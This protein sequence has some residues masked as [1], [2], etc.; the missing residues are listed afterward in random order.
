MQ[1]KQ[2]R[3]NPAQEEAVA[4]E[5]GP[6]LI[7]AGA[8]TGKT[9][10]LTSRLMKFIDAGIRPNRICAI[11]FTNKAA[12]EMADRVRS[13][14][15]EYAGAFIGTFHGLGA[16][17]LRREW[18]LL[19][20]GNNFVIFDDHDS[21]DLIK[22]IVK[23]ERW[24]QGEDAAVAKEKP[25]FF[26]NK[27]S[28]IKNK[29]GY[30]AELAS[31]KKE[32]D[33]LALKVY[34]A[35]EARLEENNALD[36][37]D[38]IEKVVQIL[39]TNPEALERH[40]KRFDAVLVDEYQDVNPKQYELVRLL[41]GGHRNVSVV[42]DDEQLIYGWRY[43]DL[44]IF[45]GFE[46]DWPGAEVK[47]LEENYRST[48]NVIEAASAVA[49]NN[50]YR[51]PK[52]LWTQNP[53]GEKIKIFEAYDENDEAELIVREIK[54]RNGLATAI[55]YRTNAQSRAIEQ[56]CIKNRIPYRIYGGLRFYE[57]KE[58]KDVIAAL[59]YGINGDEISRD[60][61]E[62]NLTK[63]KFAVFQEQASLAKQKELSPVKWIEVF[64][65]ATDYMES[66][67]KDFI[68]PEERRENIAELI[69]FAGRFDDVPKFLEE[70]TLMQ[71][72][73]ELAKRGNA[74]ESDPRAINLMTIHLAKGLEFDRVFI[75]GCN[76]GLLPHA[77]SMDNEIGVEE[78]R[79]LMYVAMTRAKREL[80]VSFYDVPS[81]FISEIPAG[82]I[83]FENRNTSEDGYDKNEERYIILD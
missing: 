20:R 50:N 42:G 40:R 33:R 59:R 29:E 73:D 31:S 17:I 37:D 64:L 75:A 51:R 41:A 71:P 62:K 3:L 32:R 36:F 61:L 67:E 63:K 43:A 13:S 78:E 48:K 21:F 79:R 5:F 52:T 11:T 47:F 76:E 27:I 25:G 9:T 38:L 74:K 10:T 45:L 14:G 81:R 24:K 54:N 53:E 6:L 34:A 28:E 77:M 18:K 80:C 39:K 35:Y 23:A 19:G 82:F 22:K 16:G 26:A 1:N 30:L 15:P 57:R 60:R 12:K 2:K 56:T 8:G 49:A 66:L 68:N 70:V 65:T 7:V 83:T 69:A 44:K 72:A 58:I 46:K 4:S 55:L